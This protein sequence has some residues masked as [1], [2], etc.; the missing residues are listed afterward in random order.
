MKR[1]L[2]CILLLAGLTTIGQSAEMRMWLS[3]KGGQL[4]AQL[5]NVQ[6]DTVTLIDKES[7][8]TR[9]KMEELSLSDRMHLVEVG[10]V[11]ET[12]IG[13]GKAGLVE[14]EIKIDSTQFKKQKEPMTF[15]D[16]M[17]K[18]FEIMETPHFLIGTSGKVQGHSIAETAERLWHGMAFQHVGFRQDWGDKHMLILLAED[19]EVFKALGKWNANNIATV[20]MHHGKDGQDA[21]AEATATWDKVAANY[22][23]LPDEMAAKDNI[24]KEALVF[25]VKE[26]NA[27][28][29]SHE[30]AR[31]RK[32]FDPFSTHVIAGHLLQITMGGGVSSFGSEGY[33]AIET[34]HSFFKEISLSGKSETSLITVSGSS[35]DEFASK[36]GFADGSSW[37]R[38]LRALVRS[39]KVSPKL[40]SMFKWKTED[41]N[42]ERLVVMYS[43]ACY[44]ETDTKRLA[45]FAKM[46]RRIDT[47]SQIPSQMEIA[48]L[49]G[50]DKVE[51]M[52]ADWIK[53]IKEGDFK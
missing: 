14:K 4:E 22:M 52:E 17:P 3:R 40:D 51:A 5:L 9:I 53:F 45:A 46:I 13:S 16:K 44:M 37:A 30:S 43:F 32:V 26:T 50:F 8:E 1:N 38:T 34:G 39:G 2:A 41:L 21:A 33:Y 47:S 6:G 12:V 23:Y 42:P 29:A 36:G 11:D 20:M 15:G 10:G 35:K 49:F 27:K 7:R 31:F 19:R 24:L 25:N 28:E 48:K 18:G